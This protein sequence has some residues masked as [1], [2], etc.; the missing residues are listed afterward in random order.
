MQYSNTLLGSWVSPLCLVLLC[1]SV[2]AT[3]EVLGQEG[4]S[5]RKLPQ[6]EKLTLRTDDGV[7]LGITY[8]PSPAGRNSVPVVML[9]DHKESRAVF[10]QLARQLQAPLNENQP[11]R[12]IVT[13]DLRGHGESTTIQNAYGQTAEIIADR[14]RPEDFR[15]MYLQDMEA[16]RKFLLE[17]NDAGQLNLNKLTLIGSGMGAN[18]AVYFAARDW[19]MPPLAARKQGQDVKAMVLASPEWGYRGL[20]L[21]PPLQQPGVREQI[22]IMIVYGEQNSRAKRDAENVHK[23]LKRFH[24]EPPPDLVRE[25]KDLF[26]VPLSTRLQGTRL[27]SDRQFNMSSKLDSFLQTRVGDQSFPWIQRKGQ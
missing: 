22:S 25:E 8:F 2:I 5:T 19:S 11:P 3:G 24:P 7:G 27:L 4:R 20:P 14:L 12:A 21:N 6:P 15:A 1:S 23:N 16:V 13:V 10:N 9:H 17:K 18:V 26:M